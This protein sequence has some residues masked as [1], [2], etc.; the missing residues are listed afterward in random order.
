[1]I[2]KRASYQS[3]LLRLW[4]DTDEETSVWRASLQSSLTGER[5]GFADLEQL[6]AFLRRQAAIDRNSHSD[7]ERTGIRQNKGRKSPSGL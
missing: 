2:K 5:Q 7:D 4:Q 6:F 3:Y 1:M